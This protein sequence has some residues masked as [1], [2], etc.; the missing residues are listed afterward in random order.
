MNISD[1]KR[2]DLEHFD[3]SV[4]D[5]KMLLSMFHE[6]GWRVFMDKVIHR[7]EVASIQTLISANPDGAQEARGI[8]SLVADIE[9]L[10][11][12][13]SAILSESTATPSKPE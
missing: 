3:L 5:A 7:A 13:V 4:A 1:I 12:A 11:E 2:D 9:E 8:L 6:E 10:P